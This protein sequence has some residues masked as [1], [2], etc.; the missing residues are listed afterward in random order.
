[1][2]HDLKWNIVMD[3]AIRDSDL[4]KLEYVRDLLNEGTEPWL[5]KLRGWLELWWNA[6]SLNAMLAENPRVLKAIGREHVSY[7]VPSFAKHA[8]QELRAP[9]NIAVW[10]FIQITLNPE[11]WRLGGC[12]RCGKVFVRQSVRASI[13]C[14]HRCASAASAVLT[15][16]KQ[17][18]ERDCRKLEAAQVAIERWEHLSQKNRATKQGWK[19]FV[20]GY[21]PAA[22]LTTKYLSRAVNSGRLKPPKGER[23]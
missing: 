9:R 7:Y 22:E 11:C 8:F 13:Y 19:E 16:K 20:A 5:P 14:S 1:M 21:D 15:Y 12:P 6:P 10:L 2:T 23:P 4:E 17:R 18:V 3:L